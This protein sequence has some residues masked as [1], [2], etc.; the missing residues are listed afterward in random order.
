[1]EGAAIGIANTALK[2]VVK[3]TLT[4]ITNEIGL[5]LGVQEEL[6]F[7]KEELEMMQGFLQVAKTEN[8]K[9]V[10][11]SIWVKQVQELAFDVE[12]CL[13]E[14]SVHLVKKS[15]LPV[16]CSVKKRD[17]IA[18]KIRMLKTRI[19]DVS[20]RNLRYEL[21]KKGNSG[22]TYDV[23]ASTR[24]IAN[25]EYLLVG[26]DEPKRKL[27][28]LICKEN[29]EV[30]SVVGMGGLGKTTLVREVFGCHEL[31]N[32]FNHFAWVTVQHPFK[33]EE[34][35]ESLAKQIP[36]DP[37]ENKSELSSK[38]PIEEKVTDYLKNKK[39][40]IVLD[41]LSSV[42]EWDKIKDVLSM[43]NGSRII[44]TTRLRPLA[45]SISHPSDNIYDIR[46]LSEKDAF[47]LFFKAVYKT[48]YYRLEIDDREMKDDLP[49]ESEEHGPLFT[50]I[51]K[52]DSE[53]QKQCMTIPI[54]KE[55][56]T[57]ADLITNSCG[58]LPLA[59]VTIGS[60]MSTKPKTSVE[61]ETMHEHISSELS[62]NPDLG[63]VK[64]AIDENI[65]SLVEDENLITMTDKVRHLVI[66]EY[67]EKGKVNRVLGAVRVPRGIG[68][69]RSLNIF[70]II[71]IG[72][73]KSLAKEMQNLTNL[74]KL[75]V[76][77]FT[78][79]NGEIL[80][81][82]ID[83]LKHLR[84]LVLSAVDDLG[85][86][87]CLES[88]SS[89]P[90]YLQ[91]LKLYGRIGKLPDWI[92]SLENLEKIHFRYTFL[93]EEIKAIG[94]LPNLKILYLLLWSFEEDVK[95]LCFGEGTFPMLQVMIL[96]GLYELESVSI[97]K[98]ALKRLEQLKISHCRFIGKGGVSGLDFLVQLKEM[99]V[100]YYDFSE[101]R[102]TITNK[103]GLQLGVEE[104]LFFIKEE[105]QMMRAFLRAAKSENMKDEIVTT[106]IKQ[107]EEL[108]FDVED[109][110]QEAS[111]HLMK[112][113]CL[114]IMCSVKKR[115]LIARKI[116]VLKTRIEDVNKRNLRYNLI[117]KEVGPHT[118]DESVFSRS[119]ANV[120]ALLVGLDEPK[121]K[122]VELI[123]KEHVEL[124][125]EPW[126]G[127]VI[128]VVGMGGL[129]KTTLV[130]E[131]YGCQELRDKFKSFAW[132]TVQHPFNIEE[133][134]ESIAK[135][136]P[137]KPE[138]ADNKSELLPKKTTK[139][140]VIEY[141]KER[142]LI[143][144]DDLSSLSEW[145]KIKHVL[146]PN[147][148]SRIIVTTRSRSPLAESISHP[149][150]NIY[151]IKELSEMDAIDLFCKAVYKTPN[152]HLAVDESM[153]SVL[154]DGEL[155]SMTDKVRH[156]VITGGPCTGGKVLESVELSHM[157]S[158][159]I[160][161]EVG[162][163]LKYSR[164][165][166]VRV[167][168]L[169]GTINLN[170]GDLRSISKL[171]HLK[172]LGLRGTKITELPNSLGELSELETLDIRN[173]GVLLLPIG[174]T[175]LHKLSYLRAG[176]VYY[177]S[178]AT[179]IVDLVDHI[180]SITENWQNKVIDKCLPTMNETAR[181]VS[182]GVRFFCVVC[183]LIPIIPSLVLEMYKESK[184]EDRFSGGVRVPQGIGKLRSLNVFGMIDI[185]GS[186]S[187]A[188]E[189]QN[190]TN[191]RKLAVSGFTKE[192]GKTLA[193][194][195]DGLK[196]L[197]SL[198]LKDAYYSGLRCCLE[199]V[200][201]PPKYLQSLKLYSSLG[202]LPDWISSL[203]NLE[204][205]HLRYTLLTGGIKAIE[206][207]PNLKI[208]Y[209]MSSSF[210]DVKELCFGKDTFPKLQVMIIEGIKELESV[211]IEKTALKRLEQLKIRR[212]WEMKEDGVSG[213]EFLEQLKE[214]EVV[215][216]LSFNLLGKSADDN[217]TY[218]Q[219]NNM[220]VS[221]LQEKLSMH[222]TKPVLRV[223]KEQ[224]VWS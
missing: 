97:K 211:V 46:E 133:F 10:L 224:D 122:L 75:A 60:Y 218:E 36:F 100:M 31:R 123:M 69:L 49:H 16:M 95:E 204:K 101:D 173:T 86:K 85:L 209:L 114:T 202:E 197:R 212:C 143:V 64:P 98:T 94:K 15:C 70:G 103:I 200:S 185:G 72:G 153:V 92:S 37:N 119:N 141:L 131:V 161:G 145:D 8:V 170:D 21:I 221:N 80:G 154:E 175:K 14:A 29:G 190:L 165:K 57:Q 4:T 47:D 196:H 41:D 208:L 71:D 22:D 81:E 110:L 149:T 2:S 108:A 191:L 142:Y 91:S 56:K 27:V 215:H 20:K 179:P 26:L 73:S 184:A 188:K 163:Y 125:D 96:E 164:M 55:M 140:K 206:K 18:K 172:Y 168:D 127:K 61:W 129:G 158:L 205:I 83:R 159:S 192:N 139:E 38:K 111:I 109:C 65:V 9:D 169:E 183:C 181:S 144:L 54:T 12:D 112:K 199:S 116:R 5:L 136:I 93:T 120:E 7:I 53:E 150:D 148:G 124:S 76:T 138:E 214:M 134:I 216:V 157:R 63:I 152:Y 176:S 39:F 35:I 90:K 171:R 25:V 17:N 107:V 45:E 130:K 217:A 13:H 33:K 174:L 24:S 113:S 105:L 147:N 117:N 182:D 58:R 187:L 68:K 213:L 223:I 203:E 32:E 87:C 30:I 194:V 89:P 167:L 156:L 23:S 67:F 222:P 132:V 189:M 1:M 151:E 155:I 11:V 6:F 34:F 3:T 44:M 48:P 193:K 186:K 51:M 121:R 62:N 106:W 59:I 198:V 79:E 88:V 82:V 195:I 40:L 126:K 219:R 52:E 162:D 160:F 102:E 207:L 137:F 201:S 99:E 118:Y 42:S 180:D 166:M 146:S 178:H 220:F 74:R 77:G 210:K 135:Q 128:S 84:S 115:D 19:V 104:E 43:V 50:E 78:E 177:I 66:T 28:Q